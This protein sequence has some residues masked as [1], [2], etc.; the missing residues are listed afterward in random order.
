MRYNV[1]LPQLLIDDVECFIF[2]GF[3]RPSFH[4]SATRQT[5]NEREVVDVVNI[6]TISEEMIPDQVT[7]D[8]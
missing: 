2:V 4:S 6:V 7:M 1:K 8:D 3:P 5:A